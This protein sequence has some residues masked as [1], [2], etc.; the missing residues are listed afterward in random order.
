MLEVGLR[1]LAALQT[2]WL[3]RGNRGLL[4]ANNTVVTHVATARGG[5]TALVATKRGAGFALE[6]KIKGPEDLADASLTFGAE[7]ATN[8][9]TKITAQPNLTPVFRAMTYYRHF[10]EGT[11]GVEALMLEGL[12]QE[13]ADLPPDFGEGEGQLGWLSKPPANSPT[14]GML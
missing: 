13:P 2:A 3:E 9:A 4:G 7:Y 14:V 5:A 8:V 6:G 11:V 1:N 12:A 10:G